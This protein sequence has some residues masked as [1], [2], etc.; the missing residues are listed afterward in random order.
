[1]KVD[2]VWAILAVCAAAI[3]LIGAVTD[4]DMMLAHAMAGGGPV[5][6]PSR[7][8]WFADT[9]NHK[10]VKTLMIV[11][12][13]CAVV[14]ALFDWWRPRAAWTARF[15]LRLRVVALSALIVPTAISLLK[16]VSFS[17]C[18]WDLTA[19]GGGQP[20]VRLLEPVISG[21]PYGHC[22]PAGHASSELWLVA[23][24]VFWL[25]EHPRKAALAGGALL[26]LGFVIGW[27]QQMRGAHF[28]THT[29]WAMWIS[30][31]L[32]TIIWRLATRK[33]AGLPQVQPS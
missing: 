16:R 21:V 14:P 13:A 17:H 26:L 9:F 19:F 31:T 27:V 33:R 30:C 22:M 15:R 7:N 24:A 1:M 18:P 32:V 4:I 23:L 2:R 6:F 10:Y 11:L 28:L 12:G 5:P 20:Y 25:P 3:V 29:L 8:A